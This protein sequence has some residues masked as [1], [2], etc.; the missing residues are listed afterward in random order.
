MSYNLGNLEFDFNISEDSTKLDL[1]KIRDILIKIQEALDDIDAR[2]IAG[3][4]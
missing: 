4:L 3:G 2:L 1:Q